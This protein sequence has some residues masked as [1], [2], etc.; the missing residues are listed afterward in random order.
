MTTN[1]TTSKFLCLSLSETFNID[2]I[3][4]IEFTKN[5]IFI[6]FVGGSIMVEA[7]CNCEN[8]TKLRNALGDNAIPQRILSKYCPP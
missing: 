8:I 6:Y 1:V 2:Y 3:A 4:K 5:K 7:D